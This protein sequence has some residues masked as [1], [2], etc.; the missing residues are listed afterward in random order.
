MNEK[1]AKESI[2]NIKKLFT[3]FKIKD[4]GIYVFMFCSILVLQTA[5]NF[6]TGMHL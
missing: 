6:I 4:C 3:E 2:G 5:Q 1:A